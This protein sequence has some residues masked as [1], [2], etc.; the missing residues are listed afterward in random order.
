MWVNGCE[1]RNWW[2]RSPNVGNSNNPRNVNT[3]GS[4]NNN[5]AIN[6]NGLAPDCVTCPLKVSFIA[7]ISATH[8][9][10][11]YPDFRKE[12]KQKHRCGLLPGSKS[13][14]SRGLLFLEWRQHGRYIKRDSLRLFESLLIDAQV[15]EKRDVER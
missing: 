2:L 1:S 11:H 9:R 14:L 12:A 13:S 4:I 7:E 6:A 3:T 10:N 8:T 15:Q 5:N